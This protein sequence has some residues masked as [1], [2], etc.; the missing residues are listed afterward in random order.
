MEQFIKDGEVKARN[1]IVIRT[2]EEMI[3]CPNDE[4]LAAHGWQ[5][6]VPVV[7]PRTMS[8]FE[9]VQNIVAKQF[10]ERKD[11]SN[12]EALE[13]MVIIRKWE[14][15]IGTTREAGTIVVYGDKPWRVRQAH[16]VQTQYPPSLDTASLYE[17]IDKKHTGDIDDPIPYTPPMEIFEGKYYTDGGVLYRCTRSSGIAL[18]HN[19]SALVGAYVAII[20]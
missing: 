12:D 13:Y 7:A 16:L 18:S 3:I 15:Y 8:P 20:N 5:P 14:T 6:Y 9:A 2:E 19:L 4:A 17:V 11:I 1:Q 10:N